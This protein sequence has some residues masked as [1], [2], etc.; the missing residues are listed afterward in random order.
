MEYT[1]ATRSN[2]VRE[3]HWLVTARVK[4]KHCN[5]GAVSLKVSAAADQ[6]S[7]PHPFQAV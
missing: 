1:T 7:T 3:S 6:L 5:S 2:Q 4:G